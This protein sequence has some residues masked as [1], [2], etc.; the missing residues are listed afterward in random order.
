MNGRERETRAEFVRRMSEAA[1]LLAEK[2]CFYTPDEQKAQKAAE[3]LR[4]INKIQQ[5]ISDF[6][7]SDERVH[8]FGHFVDRSWA[9][10]L[11][12]IYGLPETLG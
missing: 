11:I 4:R 7:N 10:T 2:Y 9:R 5:E 8:V 3:N 6:R 12:S 1:N